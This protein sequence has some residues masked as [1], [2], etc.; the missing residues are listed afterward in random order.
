[1]NHLLCSVQYLH[2]SSLGVDDEFDASYLLLVFPWTSATFD[3][4]LFLDCLVVMGP[5][6]L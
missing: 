2:E 1:M 6:S 3:D 5:L 4:D